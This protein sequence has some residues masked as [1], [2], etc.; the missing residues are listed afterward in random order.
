MNHRLSWIKVAQWFIFRI[1]SI[2]ERQVFWKLNPIF[3]CKWLY[4][5]KYAHCLYIGVC[6]EGPDETAVNYFHHGIKDLATVFFYMLVAIIMHA[7]IQEYVLDVSVTHGYKLHRPQWRFWIIHGHLSLQKINKKKHF[8]KTKHSKFNES[9]QLSAFYLFS[10]GWGASILL[11]VCRVNNLWRLLVLL[12]LRSKLKDFF[13]FLLFS[14]PSR[15]TSSRIQ[16]IYGKAI[17]IRSCRKLCCRV[18]ILFHTVVHVSKNSE[19]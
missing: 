7:I 1:R 4:H 9:G 6:S 13:F 18:R 14:S 2:W 12:F 17:L 11:S 5:Y 19:S 10:F 3:R 8:S 16:S 15:K